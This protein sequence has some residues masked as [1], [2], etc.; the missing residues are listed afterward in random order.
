LIDRQRQICGLGFANGFA[1]VDRLDHGEEIELLL[2][3]VGNAQKDLRALC[4][5]GA[6]PGL[7]RSMRGIERQFDIVGGGAGNRAN[8]MTIDR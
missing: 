4:R 1:I 6:S 5:R 8:R 7:P 3:P 2:D